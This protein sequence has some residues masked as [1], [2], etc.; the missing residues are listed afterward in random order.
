MD[1]RTRISL[2]H[3]L[4]NPRILRLLVSRYKFLTHALVWNNI[5]SEKHGLGMTGLDCPLPCTG[6]NSFQIGI[7][8]ISIDYKESIDPCTQHVLSR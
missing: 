5:G 8:K 3:H 1:A 6:S 7:I 2:G 4:L